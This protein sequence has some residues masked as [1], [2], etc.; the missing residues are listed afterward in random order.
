MLIQGRKTGKWCSGVPVKGRRYPPNS[1]L[2]VGPFLQLVRI[3]LLDSVRRVGD[4]GVKCVLR[5]ADEPIKTIRVNN[6]R[7]ADLH[8][9]I[10]GES[11]S[12]CQ[13]IFS[14]VGDKE[15]IVGSIAP[16]APKSDFAGFLFRPPTIARASMNSAQRTRIDADVIDPDHHRDK[17]ADNA[18]GRIGRTNPEAHPAA[19]ARRAKRTTPGC[20]RPAHRA[21]GFSPWARTVR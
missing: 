16:I 7:L 19:S 13:Y 11:G 3:V 20:R 2:A 8:V 6:R 12:C 14:S 9:L 5:Q 15:A 18:I 21:S 17:R 10:F 4:N 1:A